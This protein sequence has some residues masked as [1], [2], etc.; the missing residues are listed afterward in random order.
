ML[1]LETPSF[2]TYN[3]GLFLLG[4]KVF[5]KNVPSWTRACARSL[6]HLFLLK[7]IQ[8]LHTQQMVFPICFKVV[9]K[10][11]VLKA[12]FLKTIL[13][14]TKFSLLCGY[15]RLLKHFTGNKLTLEAFE[16]GSS[17]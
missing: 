16:Q 11:T 3:Q 4:S 8:N 15:F 7:N 1:R 12:D 13:V 5:T 14:W 10:Q 2:P 9:I 6:A 17:E